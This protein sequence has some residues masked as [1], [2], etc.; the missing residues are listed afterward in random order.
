MCYNRSK[1]DEESLSKSNISDG[2]LEDTVEIPKMDI[3]EDALSY[4]TPLDLYT[5]VIYLTL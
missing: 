1:E 5:F 2:D 4:M 3:I